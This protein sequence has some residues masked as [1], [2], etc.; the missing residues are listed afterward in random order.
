MVPVLYF[1]LVPFP[2][3]I[4]F[5]ERPFFPDTL[6]SSIFVFSYIVPVAIY[7]V[8]LVV[9]AISFAPIVQVVVPV[10]LFA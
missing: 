6:L 5:V 8:A 1:D 4:L 9:Y 3:N 2:L 10:H 7:A